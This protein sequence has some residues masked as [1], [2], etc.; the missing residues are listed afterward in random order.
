MSEIVYGTTIRLPTEFFL[1]TPIASG[2]SEFF[3]SLRNHFEHIRPSQGSNH[4]S[5]LTFVFKELANCEHVSFRTDAVRKPLQPQYSGTYKVIKRT[6]K[7]FIIF[8]NGKQSTVS[9]DRFK[10]AFLTNEENNVQSEPEPQ[11]KPAVTTRYGRTVRF[12]KW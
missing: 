6:A 4:S 2:D 10:P 5:K 1:P 12:P 11:S 3:T 8:L 9:V 7:N